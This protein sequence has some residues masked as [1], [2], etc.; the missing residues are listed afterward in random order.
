MKDGKD[1]D[2]E[3]SSNHEMFTLL[4]IGHVTNPNQKGKRF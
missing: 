3:N 1:V 4:H 2:V